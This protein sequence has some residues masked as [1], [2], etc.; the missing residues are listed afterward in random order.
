MI[1]IE[2]IYIVFA[3]ICLA[4]AFLILFTDNVLYAAIGLLVSLLAVAGIFVISTADFIAV[5]QIMIY[6]GG[7][8][9]LMIFGIMLSQR[10]ELLKNASPKVSTTAMSILVCFILSG[11]LMYLFSR[12]NWSQFG[13]ITD[14]GTLPTTTQPIGNE[15]MTSYLL[16]FEIIA[17]TLLITLVGAA[18]IASKALKNQ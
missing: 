14:I 8:L 1:P 3:G 18:Y 6:V 4:G 9:T 15:L 2:V 10:S 17:V 16:P 12:I 7:T 11:G 5:T 13:G